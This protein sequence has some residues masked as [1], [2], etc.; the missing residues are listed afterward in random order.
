MRP[1]DNTARLRSVGLGL[2]T[3]AAIAALVYAFV[4]GTAS[5][6]WWIIAAAALIGTVHNYRR[7]RK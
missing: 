2:L 3:L 4:S 1:H 6:T 7:S 5:I